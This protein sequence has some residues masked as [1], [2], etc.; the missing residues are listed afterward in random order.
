MY[1]SL[2]NCIKMTMNSHL[3]S[4]RPTLRSYKGPVKVLLKRPGPGGI[5]RALTKTLVDPFKLRH[6]T[7]RKGVAD[8]ILAEK[9][10]RKV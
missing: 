9:T 10:V 8:S 4:T 1:A 6:R 2:K 3:Y 7:T 5:P